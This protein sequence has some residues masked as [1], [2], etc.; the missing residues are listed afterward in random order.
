MIFCIDNNSN[1]KCVS[2]M[3]LGRL[4]FEIVKIQGN[5]KVTFRRPLCKT[6]Y[7][8][9]EHKKFIH[10]L[11]EGNVPNTSKIPLQSQVLEMVKT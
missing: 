4:I 7:T 6:S 8:I 10:I 2:N 5:V 3:S 9:D 1:C 11:Y